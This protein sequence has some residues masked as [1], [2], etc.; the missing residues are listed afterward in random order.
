MFPLDLLFYF[1]TQNVLR[2]ANFWQIFNLKIKK[3]FFRVLPIRCIIFEQP[4]R[5]ATE[6][7]KQLPCGTF[8]ALCGPCSWIMAQHRWG[9]IADV[10]EFLSISITKA[11]SVF[12]IIYVKMTFK[13]NAAVYSSC[14]LYSSGSVYLVML[15]LAATLKARPCS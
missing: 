14:Y 5:S 4:K 7:G 9:C 3:Q 10:S 13:C 2:S 1:R 8:Q 11:N 12:H 6:A 15:H